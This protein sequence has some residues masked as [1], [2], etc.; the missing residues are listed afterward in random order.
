MPLYGH[1]LNEDI[2][3]FQA[4]LGWAV[5]FD[6]GEFIG[7]AALLKHKEDTTRRRRVGL[8]LAGKRIARE[9]ARLLH[10]GKEIGDG[11]QRHLRAHA[12]QVDC[13]GLCRSGVRKSRN[14]VRS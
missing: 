3:P 4:G 2:D 5:K 9:G 12:R 8:E 10:E 11:H 14:R 7:R 13:H 1:E 6:K